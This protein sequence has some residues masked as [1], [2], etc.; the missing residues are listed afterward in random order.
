[1]RTTVTL[2]LA[3]V[4]AFAAGATSGYAA[5]AVTAPVVRAAT[6][7]SSAACPPGSHPA[8]WY[9]ARTWSCVPNS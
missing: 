1:M 6:T 9:T 2:V 5:R 8:V 7:H 4:V 3:I